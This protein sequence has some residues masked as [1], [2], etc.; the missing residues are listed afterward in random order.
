M[1]LGDDDDDVGCGQ[2]VAVA[3]RS[4]QLGMWYDDGDDDLIALPDKLIDDT[5]S[6]FSKFDSKLS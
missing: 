2:W 1:M 3:I 5:K 4:G 6:V